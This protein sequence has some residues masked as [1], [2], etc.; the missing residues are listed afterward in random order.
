MRAAFFWIAEY[1]MNADWGYARQRFWEKMGDERV[2][3]RSFVL[4]QD[5][6]EILV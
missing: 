1:G 4:V 5:G 3:G 6:R 2:K